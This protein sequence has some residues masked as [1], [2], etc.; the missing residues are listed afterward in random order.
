LAGNGN[1]FEQQVDRGGD[2][3]CHQR[4]DEPEQGAP[5]EGG[6]DGESRVTLTVCFITRGLTRKSSR[7]LYT[8]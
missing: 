1:L 7:Y 4:A 8:T 5:D 3:D 2:R 6:D